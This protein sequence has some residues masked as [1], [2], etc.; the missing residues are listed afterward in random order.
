MVRIGTS[1]STVIDRIFLDDIINDIERIVDRSEKY[2]L[3]WNRRDYSVNLFILGI[4]MQLDEY[5]TRAK[6]INTELSPMNHAEVLRRVGEFCLNQEVTALQNKGP[7]YIREAF[8]YWKKSVKTETF[9]EDELDFEIL[10]SLKKAKLNKLALECEKLYLP[11]IKALPVDKQPFIYVKLADSLIG[12]KT[13]EEIK[14]YFNIAEKIID[15]SSL[16]TKRILAPNDYYGYSQSIRNS[17]TKGEHAF[18]LQLDLAK[19]KRDISALKNLLEAT[20]FAVLYPTIEPVETKLLVAKTFYEIGE[21]SQA[22]DILNNLCSRLLSDFKEDSTTSPPGLS[23]LNDNV[24]EVIRMCIVLDERSIGKQLLPIIKADIDNPHLFY[25]KKQLLLELGEYRE[26]DLRGDY[27]KIQD[28]LKRQKLDFTP[29][30][31]QDYIEKGSSFGG[32]SNKPIHEL[33]KLPSRAFFLQDA[34]KKQGVRPYVVPALECLNDLVPLLKFAKQLGVKDIE[35]EIEELL[36]EYGEKANEN[37]KKA[38]LKPPTPPNGWI[39]PKD[40]IKEYKEGNIQKSDELTTQFEEFLMNA[41][42]KI[43]STPTARFSHLPQ[44]DEKEVTRLEMLTD[45]ANIYLDIN[46][47]EK[48]SK[49]LEEIKEFFKVNDIRLLGFHYGDRPFMLFHEFLGLIAKSRFESK[50]L[51]KWINYT[52]QVAPTRLALLGVL[53]F[54]Y[55]NIPAAQSVLDLIL[56]P[57]KKDF[58]PME[59]LYYETKSKILQKTGEDEEAKKVLKLIG[60]DSPKFGNTSVIRS[61]GNL[62]KLLS[63][64]DQEKIQEEILSGLR[65]MDPFGRSS[66]KALIK[67]ELPGEIDIEIWNHA[68]SFLDSQLQNVSKIL[69]LQGAQWRFE[70]LMSFITIL[71]ELDKKSIAKNYCLVLLSTIQ[72]AIESL[73]SEEVI[74]ELEFIPVKE[75]PLDY[76]NLFAAAVRNIYRLIYVVRD[77]WDH[78]KTT[79][80]DPEIHITQLDSLY[81]KW[82]RESNKGELQNIRLFVTIPYLYESLLGIFL[83]LEDIDL[84]LLCQHNLEALRKMRVK[85]AIQESSS[86][87]LNSDWYL[88]LSALAEREDESLMNNHDFKTARIQFRLL[89]DILNQPEMKIS[90][91]LIYSI[92]SMF[93]RFVS[94]LSIKEIKKFD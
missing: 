75:Q 51:S 27:G 13:I 17:I 52:H 26:D 36:E 93:K 72:D 38:Q 66:L 33:I 44:V 35:S 80:N 77:Y 14:E 20:E 29:R 74:K 12:I 40:I 9:S 82:I 18:N 41:I 71:V 8:S 48:A 7:S 47:R 78:Y 23:I 21:E 50:E 61:M 89:L 16:D 49:I 81:I 32:I 58:S 19:E 55:G 30:K 64:G 87:K 83:S 25:Y 42:D 6:K 92:N 90:E 2:D 4:K 43:P 68:R 91:N 24:I 3:E 39:A 73:A 70:G 5:I 53:L 28:A 86:D 37:Y 94:T 79:Q 31:F 59:S 69:E 10:N 84:S 1:A 57:A 11:Q 46:K 65:K 15:D 88:N 34:S 76:Q 56:F 45:L 85:Q 22:R 54:K 62:G 67:D 63:V 60:K